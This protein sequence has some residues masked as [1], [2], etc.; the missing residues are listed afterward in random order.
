MLNKPFHH[1]LRR[2]LGRISAHPPVMISFDFLHVFDSQYLMLTCRNHGK[3]DKGLHRVQGLSD[4]T[5]TPFRH[6]LHLL[7]KNL[8]LCDLPRFPYQGYHSGLFN[9]ID[10]GNFFPLNLI[11]AYPPV[12]WMVSIRLRMAKAS[13]AISG[14][15]QRYWGRHAQSAYLCELA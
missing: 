13:Q 8:V 3:I 1:F 12:S 5:L 2:C 10:L 6:K 14:A 7:S 9:T 4:K 11:M 15:T